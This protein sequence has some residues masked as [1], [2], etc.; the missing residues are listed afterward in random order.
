MPRMRKLVQSS[1]L[2]TREGSLSDSLV[3]IN[4]ELK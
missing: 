2:E 4:F 3:D 1:N